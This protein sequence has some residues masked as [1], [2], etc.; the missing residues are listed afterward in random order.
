MTALALERAKRRTAL[1]AAAMVLGMA[2]LGYAA[3]PL[4]DLFCRVT[5][6]GG[7]TMRVDAAAIPGA[8]A[9][10]TIRIRFDA[11]RSPAIP[12]EFRPERAVDTIALGGRDMAFYTAKNLSDRPV[13]GT[14]SYNVSPTSAGRYFS[15]IECF[16]FTE[17]TLE[18]GQEVRM[19]VIFFID[20]AILEDE[21]A[22]KIEEITLSYTF[23]PVEPGKTRG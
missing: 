12:W 8:V 18:P 6:F 19:P 13:T 3:V 17:Q 22:A 2:A 1:L 10:K 5:G 23:F 16:C 20:P 9:G 14:A 7:T 21:D 15:K 11:N 4:Y